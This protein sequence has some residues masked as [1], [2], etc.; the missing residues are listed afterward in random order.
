MKLLTR[1][2]EKE[3]A[4]Y[5]L[6]SQQSKGEDAEVVCKFFSPVG[7]FTWY[8]LEG[9]YLEFDEIGFDWQFFGI[10][11]NNYGEKE[12]GYFNLSELESIRLPHGLTIER[13]IWFEKCKVKYIQQ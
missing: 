8:V 13:D 11:I 2:I 10:V 12:Y 9:E 1:S 6:Y 7:A 5:P 3:L 4:K